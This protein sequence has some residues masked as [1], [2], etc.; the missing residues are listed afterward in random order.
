MK[1][2]CFDP[3][4][5]LI[6]KKL[7][8]LAY[9]DDGIEQSLADLGYRL[10]TWIG[11]VKELNAFVCQN[12][13]HAVLVFQGTDVDE[14]DTIK[15]DLK[16]GKES[17]DGVKYD[18]GCYDE[19]TRLAPMFVDTLATLKSAGVKLYVA[20]HSLGGGIAGVTMLRLPDNTFEACYRAGGMRFCDKA[21]AGKDVCGKIFNV[22][23]ENDVVP[24][25]PF[26]ALGFVSAGNLIVITRDGRMYTGKAAYWRRVFYVAMPFMNRAIVD[27]FGYI[28]NHVLSAYIPAMKNVVAQLSL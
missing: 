24:L 9:S 20:G 19:Y 10:V 21:G 28:K 5:A 3:K 25:L 13:D 23:L 6:F 26:W 18:H 4:L 11:K 8:L 14:P 27:G 16:F 7:M 1:E 17:I 22:V 15:A 12:A 2:V